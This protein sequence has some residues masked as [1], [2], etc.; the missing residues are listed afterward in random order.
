LDGVMST[1][2]AR[3]QDAPALVGIERIAAAVDFHPEGE[4]AAVLGAVIAHATG[5]DLLLAAIEPD[6]PFV[7]P[8]VDR[9]SMRRQTASM[10]G[11][12]RDSLT[13]GARII[14]DRDLSIA[15]GISRVIDKQHRQLL[16]CG[17]SRCGPAGEVSIGRTTRQ[18]L[19][20]VPCSLA[21]APRGLSAD[22]ELQFAR[23]GVGFDGGDESR[24]ALAVA[25]TIARGAGAE[26][27]VRGVVD[28]QL[29]SLGW[30]GW[31]R[32]PIREAWRE[33]MGEE[34]ASMRTL[35]DDAISQLGV[36]VTAE[37]KRDVPAAS[38]S[39]LS[40]DVDLLVI[41]SRRWGPLARLLLRGT[42]EALVHG[43]RCALLVVP[44]PHDDRSDAG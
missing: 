6:R 18:L 27:L 22:R 7:I 23:I 40:G 39:E 14:V 17:S 44:R 41:G 24:A 2:T 25:A 19:D 37:V 15:R 30:P 16:V 32:G 9:R 10:L 1:E 34:V 5:G 26:L 29:P 33:V 38:L 21:I 20:R 11:R 8:G 35:I 3:R 36:P 42:G 43:S 28:D 13:P 31:W 4:D 12:A